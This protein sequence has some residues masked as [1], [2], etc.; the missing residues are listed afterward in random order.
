MTTKSIKKITQQVNDITK[1]WL[2]SNIRPDHLKVQSSFYHLSLP[3]PLQM[4]ESLVTATNGCHYLYVVYDV[5]ER[6][7]FPLRFQPARLEL[8]EQPHMV[9]F[10]EPFLAVLHQPADLVPQFNLRYHTQAGIEH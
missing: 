3:A 1:D 2:I 9:Q 5:G 10:C 6:C 8:F 7:S 4:T